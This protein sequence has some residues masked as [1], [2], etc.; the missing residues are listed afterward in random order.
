[1]ETVESVYLDMFQRYSGWNRN[2]FD[3][4]YVAVERGLT[5]LGVA[6]GIA[7]TRE[8]DKIYVLEFS[9]YQ[10]DVSTEFTHDLEFYMATRQPSNPASTT[11]NLQGNVAFLQTGGTSQVTQYIGADLRQ[12]TEALQRLKTAATESNEKYAGTISDLVDEAIVVSG[13]EGATWQAV[14]KALD[15]VQN[16]IRTTGAVP[17][18]WNLVVGI[19]SAHGVALPHLPS[20]P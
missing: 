13:K 5:H 3:D 12:A 7:P 17:A 6:G 19:A 14:A 2:S 16:L 8:Q 9:Q 18:A 4:L 15:G 10:V 1:M 20:A 11:I